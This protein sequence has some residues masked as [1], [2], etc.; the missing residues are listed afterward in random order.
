[1]TPLMVA[2]AYN[3]DPEVITVLLQAG[4]SINAQNKYGE[5][6]LVVAAGY[7]Q[8]PAVIAVLLK[9][10][11]DINARNEIGW[12]ALM[13]AAEKNTS[14]D[15]V[16]VLLKAGADIKARDNDGWTALMAAAGVNQN[17][18]V[19]TILVNPMGSREIVEGKKILLVIHEAFNRLWI[20]RPKAFNEQTEGLQCVFARRGKR[21]LMEHPFGL[22]LQHI[23]ELVQD[24]PR[25]MEPAALDA[26]IRPY[27]RGG[28][29]EAH[30]T[31]A[32]G[33]RR[34]YNKSSRSEVPQKLLPRLGAFPIAVGNSEQF[35]VTRRGGAHEDQ[36]TSPFILQPG[37]AVHPVRPDVDIPFPR[38][39]PHGPLAILVG[40]DFLE[41]YD[42]TRR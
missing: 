22:G 33:K 3:Q 6:P 16:S 25:L 17:P 38:K 1:M 40:P 42:G 31:V 34:I 8:N 7:N 26:C 35:L 36:Q 28:R 32:N 11:A 9:A 12:T 23:G 27:L 18:E 4:A 20:L 41:S 15:V 37:A 29:L 19:A 30:S 24:I 5:T 10:G 13:A 39:I 2:A 21:L 14:P